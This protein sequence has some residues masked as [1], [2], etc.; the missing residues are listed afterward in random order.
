L[1]VFC[2]TSEQLSERSEFC[3]RAKYQNAREPAGQGSG[4]PSFW[5]LFLGHARKSPSRADKEKKKKTE[6]VKAR[7]VEKPDLHLFFAL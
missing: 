2:E 5:V 1:P 7:D 6:A 4:W 3:S